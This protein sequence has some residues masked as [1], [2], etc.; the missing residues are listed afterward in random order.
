LP[1]LQKPPRKAGSSSRL[2]NLALC[3]H[4]PARISDCEADNALGIVETP[5]PI[6][7]TLMPEAVTNAGGLPL[8]SSPASKNGG[9]VM[10]S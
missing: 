6:V 4:H 5:A 7:G 8:P 10:L 1:W 9:S 2:P 3:R